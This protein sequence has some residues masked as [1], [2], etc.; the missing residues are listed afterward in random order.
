[1]GQK[2]ILT[3]FQKKIFFVISGEKF[4]R[5]NFYFSGGTALAE[6]YL[7]HRY[8]EDLDF[9]TLKKISYSQIQKILNLK[10]AKM[11]VDNFET[12]AIGGTKIFFFKR[13]KKEVV[14]VEFD[15]FPFKRLQKGKKFKGIEIDSL[16]DLAV[17]K[18]NTIL[19]RRYARDYIDLYFILRQ[20]EYSWQKLLNGI[21][22]KFSWQVDPFNLAVRLGKIEELHD[23]PRMIKKFSRSQMIK[24]Y[25]K[26]A[27]HFNQ[28]IF[29][30]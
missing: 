25:Q 10:M 8:S 24:F 2:S 9:F 11:G 5:E 16:F 28:K 19:T 3:N 26:Q 1:V 6:F 21:R 27:I 30:D 7:K 17:N 23:Y 14:K 20:E 22:K 12:R 4:F 13:E 18:L 15:Y 29:K